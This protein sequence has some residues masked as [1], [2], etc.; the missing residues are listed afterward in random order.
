MASVSPDGQVMQRDL[1]P[2]PR[3]RDNGCPCLCFGKAPGAIKVK[4]ITRDGGKFIQKDD[5]RIVEYFVY[6][7]EDPDASV[8]LQINGSM[9]TGYCESLR[10]I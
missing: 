6:G 5:G 1:K 4:R 7:S 8:M 9:G 10:Q 3:N 2:Q